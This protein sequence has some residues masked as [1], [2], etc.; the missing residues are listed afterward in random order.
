M[1]IARPAGGYAD[2]MLDPGAWPE[3]DEG[4][5]YDR[6]QDYTRVLR[7]V[8]EVLESCQHQRSEVFDGGIWSGGAANAANAELGANVGELM[9]LQNGLAAIITWDRYIALSIEQTKSDITDNVEAAQRQISLLE[10]DSRLDADER[11]TAINN[12]VV[13]TYGANISLMEGAADRILASKAWKPPGNALDD[14][15]DQKTPPPLTLPDGTPHVPGPPPEEDGPRPG[16]VDPVPVPPAPPPAPPVNPSLPS[17][18]SPMPGPSPAPPGPGMPATPGQPPGSPVS[19][20]GLPGAATP[21]QPGAASPGGP[22][23]GS[24]GPGAPAG[25]RGPGAPAAPLGPAAP[26]APLGPAAS[27]Q[28]GG[29]GKGVLPASATAGSPQAGVRP[30]ESSAAVTPAG[31]AGMPGAPMAGGSGGASGGS[32]ARAGAPPVGQSPSSAAPSTRPAAARRPAARAAAAAGEGKPVESRD[33]AD[34]GVAVP[35][36]VIP[37]SAARAERDAIAEA[38]TADAA[39]R[40]GPDP[41]QLARRIAAALN[42]PDNQAPG[43]LGFFWVTAVTTDGAIVVANS[44]GVA[45]I[46]EQVQLPEQVEMAS[47]DAAIPAA[48][49]ARWATYPVLA[50]QGW[51]E[52]HDKK[53][54]AVI[55]TEKHFAGSDP[56]AAKIFLMPDDI[57]ETGEMAGRSRLEAVDPPAAERLAATSDRRLVELL[58]PAPADRSPRADERAMLWFDVVKPLASKATGRTAAHLRAFHNYTSHCAEVALEQAHTAADLDA[59]RLAVA[60]WLY[61]THLAA[62]LDEALAAAP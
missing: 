61:W 13:A 44:Y 10:R 39:R 47:A 2:Q 55:A 42:A 32:G 25:P 51:A 62:L 26:A 29:S 38:A 4:A 59:Q 41:L 34:S 49:R 5:L 33:D 21:G 43:A 8:T 54:R 20:P 56:G 7:Q 18:G 6:A 28:P 15:L 1:G 36:P 19:A 58:P 27:A 24:P 22:G 31:A 3:V 45:Y 11:A 16:P 9:T 46:P 40:G 52:H 30:E 48:E 57:P 17:P 35:P 53:L 12:V 60:D 14:L 23:G 50:V 37:V